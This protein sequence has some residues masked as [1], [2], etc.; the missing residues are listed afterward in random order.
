ML[1]PSCRYGTVPV[2]H[3]TGGLKDTVL[4]YDP[5][6]GA[7]PALLP[8]PPPP[9]PP[10]PSAPCAAAWLGRLPLACTALFPSAPAPGS[11]ARLTGQASIET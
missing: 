10:Q 3:S 9:P 4:N 6:Q 7:C 5:F 2:A 1:L 11:G 8:L